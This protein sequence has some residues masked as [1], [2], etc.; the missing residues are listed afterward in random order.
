MKCEDANLEMSWPNFWVQHLMLAHEILSA[1]KFTNTVQYSIVLF[2][3]TWSRWGHSVSCM[4]T[5]SW[6]LQIT[7]SDI[8]PHIKWA[9]SRVIAYG[10]FNFSS[11]VCVGM[12]GLTYSLD[13]PPRVSSQIQLWNKL[14]SLP[15]WHE[16]GKNKDAFYYFP[17]LMSLW[18][19]SRPAVLMYLPAWK[20]S[21]VFNVAFL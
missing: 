4:T 5:L 19:N 6:N 13:H 18:A 20:I 8:R 15:S 21:S 1:L 16:K 7:R 3:D 14:S 9:V 2:N 11:G 10:H 17:G 12:Y